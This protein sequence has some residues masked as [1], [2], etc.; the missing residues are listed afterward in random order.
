MPEGHDIHAL[1]VQRHLRDALSMHALMADEE[2]ALVPHDLPLAG[3]GVPVPYH[4]VVTHLRI[5]AGTATNE[6]TMYLL[7]AKE[8]AVAQER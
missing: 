7:D 5:A 8:V 4:K 2:A 6:L 1:P 3:Q